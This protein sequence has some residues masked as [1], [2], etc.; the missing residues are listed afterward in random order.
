MSSGI[1]YSCTTGALQ[2]IQEETNH[3]WAFAREVGLDYCTGGRI[4]VND[5][6]EL[7]FRWYI[8]NGTLEIIS[9]NGKEKKIWHDQPRRDDKNVKAPNQIYQRFHELFRQST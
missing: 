7:L 9:E 6:W 5:L 1:D 8:D 2:D 4:Y 3:L